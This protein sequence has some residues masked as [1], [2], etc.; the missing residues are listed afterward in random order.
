MSGAAFQSRFRI[1]RLAERISASGGTSLPLLHSSA[2]AAVFVF[3]IH[4]RSS[5]KSVLRLFAPSSWQ[6][7]FLGSSGGLALLLEPI[8]SA[9][10]FAV[11]HPA[12]QQ[13]LTL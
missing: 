2:L 6:R 9:K 12:P 11:K 13:R 3:Q 8:L 4:S 5:V 1:S 10:S 7:R